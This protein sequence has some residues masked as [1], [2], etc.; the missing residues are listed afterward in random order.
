MADR[1]GRRQGILEQEGTEAT[2]KG[3]CALSVLLFKSAFRICVNLRD[4][5]AS[6]NSAA[7]RRPVRL[8][9]RAMGQPGCASG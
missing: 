3:V 9:L 5:Q 1:V 8:A 4:P 6:P 2:E 7:F